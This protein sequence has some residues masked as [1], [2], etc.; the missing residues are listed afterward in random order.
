MY[1]N[2]RKVLGFKTQLLTKYLTHLSQRVIKSKDLLN[3]LTCI[4]LID[5]TKQYINSGHLSIT[6]NA[7]SVDNR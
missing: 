1:A 6:L 4:V 5:F 2:S 3:K 7:L